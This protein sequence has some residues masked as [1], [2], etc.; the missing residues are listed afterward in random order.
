MCL[1]QTEFRFASQALCKTSGLYRDRNV[2]WFSVA[3]QEGI[4]SGFMSKATLATLK[5]IFPSGYMESLSPV[6]PESAF[7]V[8]TRS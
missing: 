2:G 1:L 5:E 8:G 6:R 3:L 4:P 7:L